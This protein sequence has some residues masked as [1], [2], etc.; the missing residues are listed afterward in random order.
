[1]SIFLSKHPNIIFSIEKE[2][3]RCLPFLDVNI[4]RENLQLKSIE[5]RPSMGFM[6]T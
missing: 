3:D 2:K 4:F 5:Q 1:M 6:P